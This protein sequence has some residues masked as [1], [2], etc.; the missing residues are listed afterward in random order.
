MAGML[1]GLLPLAYFFTADINA[2]MVWGLNEWRSQPLSRL[3]THLLRKEYGTFQLVDHQDTVSRTA[4][5]F[6]R[7]AESVMYVGVPLCGIAPWM[8]IKNRSKEIVESTVNRYLFLI[9]LLINL[10]L[11]TIFF[12][13][14]RTHQ[15]AFSDAILSRF[16]ALPALLLAPLM[17]I[18]LDQIKIKIH[19]KLSNLIGIVMIIGS[20]GIN[21]A[22][23]D[24]RYQRLPEFTIKTMLDLSKNGFLLG[25]SD[26]SWAGVP[27][28]QVV[29]HYGHGVRFMPI[30]HLEDKKYREWYFQKW[31]LPYL[32]WKSVNNFF[33]YAI[34]NGGLVF[35]TPPIG[36]DL[37]KR[38][39]SF[40]PSYIATK[41]EIPEPPGLFHMN[42]ALYSEL[43]KS[44][45]LNKSLITSD[46]ELYILQRYAQP[47]EV[48][49][50]S[51]RDT[52]PDLALEAEKFRER[53]TSPR[54]KTDDKKS[55][56]TG[57]NAR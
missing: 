44:N 56:T 23:S 20:I 5:L 1:A 28:L 32:D 30:S 48:L 41:G 43:E 27:F 10:F 33:D 35:E 42:K 12:L 54:I 8:T 3:L 40:G 36:S 34:I 55:I 4:F 38:I 25:D 14:A 21:L 15:N 2:P 57:P 18:G 17:A 26:F 53:Y 29:R 11:I 37:I 9:C 45:L 49:S 19:T 51:L 31:Q 6:Q 16:V 47:W 39:Y 7:L 52:H 50:D 46:W 22:S 24:R 13:L